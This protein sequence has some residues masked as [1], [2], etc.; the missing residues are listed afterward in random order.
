MVSRLAREVPKGRDT[1]WRSR[2]HCLRSTRRHV[3]HS[4]SSCFIPRTRRS[5]IPSLTTGSVPVS[6]GRATERGSQAP[7]CYRRLILVYQ[8]VLQVRATSHPLSTVTDRLDDR[9]PKGPFICTSWLP[10][11]RLNCLLGSRDL[12]RNLSVNDDGIGRRPKKV[13][14]EI[15]DVAAGSNDSDG[16]LDGH[17]PKISQGPRTLAAPPTRRS[18]ALVPSGPSGGRDES[19][20]RRTCLQNSHG[21]H[22][23]DRDNAYET[24]RDHPRPLEEE[25]GD[26]QGQRDN[27][28]NIFPKGRGPKRNALGLWISWV[29]H[30]RL[31]EVLHQL[32]VT[33]VV[34]L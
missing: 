4:R 27:Q 18:G 16:P 22:R 23:P 1:D 2:Q 19:G 12:P 28:E 31:L 30:F 15:P 26:D 24:E 34:P 6:R 32:S 7:G 33:V 8:T 13:V 14:E 10:G 21:N 29:G 9:R 17:R 3:V 11:D 25:R 5:G 20:A